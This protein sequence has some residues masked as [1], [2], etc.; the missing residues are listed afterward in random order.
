M[1][2]TYQSAILGGTFDHFHIGHEAF[3]KKAFN[4]SQHVT[5]GIVDTPLSHDK[6]YTNSI[7][8]Y[9]I[10][11]QNLSSFLG[12]MGFLERSSI[13]PIHDIYGTTLTD[14]SIEAIYVTDSTHPNAIVINEKRAS[15][16]LPPLKIISLP[17]VLAEDGE[18]ISSSFIRT[19]LID[20]MGHSYLKFFKSRTNYVLPDNLRAK[21]QQPMGIV[22]TDIKEISEHVFVSSLVI[23]V[24]DVVTMEL[25]NSSHSP[26]ICLVDFRTKRQDIDP[27]TIAKYFPIISKT[28]S[29]PAGT[30]NSDFG[31]IFLECMA[32]YQ[33]DH[34]EQ[35]IKVEGEE[36]LLALPSMLMAPLDSYII[37]GQRDVGICIVKVTPDTKK[38]VANLLN[39][40]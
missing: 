29:N 25:I 12:N 3:I 13:I 39:Q 17:H 23:S 7:E 19:G 14:Q 20:R 30:I 26:S 40:F 9:V 34:K 22:V 32:N 38:Y 36:D 6:S 11:L 37:Y 18:L 24:G 4:D 5:I 27:N 35:I 8:S 28:I 16:D 21:L 1:S 33:K 2:Y 10:R 15:L 31:K